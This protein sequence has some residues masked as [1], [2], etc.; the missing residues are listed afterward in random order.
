MDKGRRY[1]KHWGYINRWSLNSNGDTIHCEREP[2]NTRKNYYHKPQ[3]SLRDFWS[4]NDKLHISN[5]IYASIGHGGGTRLDGQSSS[6][7]ED[8]Q[9]NLQPIYD[10]NKNDIDALY[11]SDLKKSK[12]ILKSSINNQ[13][14]YG[15]L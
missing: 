10:Q 12:T 2:L 13:Y 14:W 6:F 5:I 11:S 7:D 9:L 15:V 8:G 3:F 4:V 1:N